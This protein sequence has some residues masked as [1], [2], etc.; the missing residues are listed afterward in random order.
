[1]RFRCLS[2]MCKMNLINANDDVCLKLGLCIWE[3]QRLWEVYICAD[4]PEPS[5]LASA[6]STKSHA[7]AHA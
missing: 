4:S 3:Q 6:I 7:L 1:M 5:L 2:H